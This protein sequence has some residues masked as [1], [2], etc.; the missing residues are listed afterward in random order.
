MG[1]DHLGWGWCKHHGGNS[2]SGKTHAARLQAEAAKAK[3]FMGSPEPVSPEE[4]LDLALRATHAH[5]QWLQRRI[6]ETASFDQ[7]D[8]R[9]LQVYVEE[10]KL[11]QALAKSA[12]DLSIEDRKIRLGT[13]QGELMFRVFQAVI[14]SPILSLTP[15][16]RVLVQQVVKRELAQAALPGGQEPAIDVESQVTVM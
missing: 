9:L 14:G 7:L 8:H 4:A 16:Q 11:L 13:Q 10:R 15:E 3:I 5:V 2:H 1:T 6:G 12:G